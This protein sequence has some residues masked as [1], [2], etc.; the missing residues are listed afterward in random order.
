MLAVA[1]HRAPAAASAK[2]VPSNIKHMRKTKAAAVDLVG[3]ICASRVSLVWPLPQ[4]TQ[5]A[6]YSACGQLAGRSS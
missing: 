6:W 5:W 3:F 1:A 2:C 4:K